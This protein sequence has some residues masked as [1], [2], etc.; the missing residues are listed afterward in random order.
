MNGPDLLIFDFDGVLCRAESFTPDAIRAGLRR[1]GEQVGVPIAVPDE[2]TLLATLGYPSHQT[3]PPL[4]PESVRARWSE[5][6]G[7]TLDA[8]EERIRA[9]GPAC[10]YDG[11]ADLLDALVADGRKLALASNSSARYQQVHTEVHRL[12]HWFAHLWHAQA[13]G[14]GSKADMVARILA[15]EPGARQPVFIG[16]RL[17]DRNAAAAHGVPFVACSYGF[18][19]AAEWEGAVAVVGSV[20]ELGAW[21]GVGR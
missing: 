16:D 20:A 15:A 18:G 21:L 17:S 1:F 3:Y 8:M 13:P 11:V 6:H 4:L 7:F 14:I 10:L 9:L 12:E 19:C 2:A 5:M